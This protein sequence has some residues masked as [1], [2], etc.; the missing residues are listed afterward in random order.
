MFCIEPSKFLEDLPHV[1][2]VLCEGH[3]LRVAR[4]SDGAVHVS[5]RFAILTVRDSNHGPAELSVIKILLKISLN[6]CPKYELL[7]NLG[8]ARRS[9]TQII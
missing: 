1:D 5:A 7:W 9:L 4:D 8:G 6:R 2:Q 3:R